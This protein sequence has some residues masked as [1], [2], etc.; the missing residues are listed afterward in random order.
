MGVGVHGRLMDIVDARLIVCLVV[1]VV[2]SIARGVGRRVACGVVAVG[3]GVDRRVSR[4]VERHRVV[5]RIV[6]GTRSTP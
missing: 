3:R 1:D 4:C 6:R 2:G 5:C